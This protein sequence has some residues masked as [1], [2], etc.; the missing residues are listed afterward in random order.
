MSRIIHSNNARRSLLEGGLLAAFGAMLPKEIL[1]APSIT[2]EAAQARLPI[3]TKTIPSTGERLPA[4]G[5]GTSM[6]TNDQYAELRSVLRRMHDLGGTVIDT[7]ND[8][9][10]SEMIIGKA[11]TEL[12][13][14]RKMFVATK[15]D[16]ENGHPAWVND[17]IFGG[18]SFD[19]S[20]QLLARRKVDLI[21]AHHLASVDHL[22]P[23]LLEWKR[24]GRTRYIGMGTLQPT[25]HGA[26]MDKMRQYPMMDFIEVDYS[27][28]S[29]DAA[30]DIFP[31]AMKY[32]MAVV[33]DLPLS[34]RQEW[35][36][37]HA[38]SLLPM[39]AGRSLPPWA[40]KIGVTSWSQFF[41]KYIISHPAVTCAIPGTTKLEHLVDN[42]LAC[43][44]RLPDAAMRN[45]M[46]EYWDAMA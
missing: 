21:F 15:C 6:F 43:H 29:R 17:T 12:G 18:E 11:L 8:Y 32:K 46:E 45:R 10:D 30:T 31:L 19:R 27:I 23:L 22:M 2:P 4:I 3:I 16:V 5:I 20:L 13:L 38:P 39:V 44:G 26:L 28:A 34:A 40:T 41:L 42:Q 1:G 35:G 14:Q 24:S 7:S 33:V 36:P 25:E 9:H 37:T